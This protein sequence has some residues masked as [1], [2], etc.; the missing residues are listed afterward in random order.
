MSEPHE[1][2]CCLSLFFDSTIGVREEPQAGWLA[3]MLNLTLPL[4]R[5]RV[6][7]G[8]RSSPGLAQSLPPPLQ[9]NEY[10]SRKIA[11]TMLLVGGSTFITF[12]VEDRSADFS[13]QSPVSGMKK[14]RGFF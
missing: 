14:L 5:V 8:S 12:F 11:S 1:V 7:S 4:D 2:D 6:C 13:V 10:F 3:I 9:Y